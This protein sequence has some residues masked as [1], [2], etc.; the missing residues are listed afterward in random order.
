[1]CSSCPW[2]N[3]SKSQGIDIENTRL[4]IQLEKNLFTNIKDDRFIIRAIKTVEE[5]VDLGE[6][7]FEPYVIM[8][9]VQLFRKRK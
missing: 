5:A 2:A 3:D 6:V 1:M 8:E 4:Y 9:G 7:G